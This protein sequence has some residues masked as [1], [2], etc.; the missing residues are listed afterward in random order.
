MILFSFPFP[1]L[2]GLVHQ[3]SDPTSTYTAPR[4]KQVDSPLADPEPNVRH[5]IEGS[6]HESE[7]SSNL[8]HS[9]SDEDIAVTVAAV[10]E[11]KKH[12]LHKEKKVKTEKQVTQDQKQESFQS[13]LH[14]QQDVAQRT[15]ETEEGE[16]SKKKAKPDDTPDDSIESHVAAYADE[17]DSIEHNL[18]PKEPRSMTST[19]QIPPNPFEEEMPIVDRPDIEQQ[20]GPNPFDEP[21]STNPFDEPTSTKT[22]D[23]PEER[24][25]DE[26]SVESDTAERND[27]KASVNVPTSGSD[28]Y[29]SYFYGSPAKK[30]PAVEAKLVETQHGPKDSDIRPEFAITRQESPAMPSLVTA[31]EHQQERQR[32]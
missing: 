10:P 11:S 24:K 5:V 9:P 31:M 4:T 19:S 28:F 13:V 15:E 14:Q 8:L 23:D 30:K 21:A 2:T 7:I 18:E 25:P 17:E 20:E 29:G 12:S 26:P 16:S 3:Y 27:L 32:R 6:F 22:F 1:G